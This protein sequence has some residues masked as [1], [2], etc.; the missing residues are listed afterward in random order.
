M[1]GELEITMNAKGP[2]KLRHVIEGDKFVCVI[3][4]HTHWAQMAVDH[5]QFQTF[6]AET[7]A[8]IIEY[9]NRSDTKIVEVYSIERKPEEVR[10]VTQYYQGWYPVTITSE[11]CYFD[12]KT[13]YRR[14]E[15]HYQFMKDLVQAEE[16]YNRVVNEYQRFVDATGLYLQDMNAN[17][18]LVTEKFDDFRL[19][20]IAS[21]QKYEGPVE[22]DP[23]G[24]LL[25]GKFRWIH[26][27]EN[28]LGAFDPVIFKYMPNHEELLTLV[29]R[30][31]KPRI[32]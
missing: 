6:D 16:F 30:N 7:D 13:F 23:I 14:G 15:V 1:D 22:V 25:T 12:E 9:T 27:S 20:D 24:V 28:N 19:V 18:I 4:P 31:I 11:N 3:E 5:H 17:N 2:N 21:I 29:D 8:K 10:I 32:I 26:Y